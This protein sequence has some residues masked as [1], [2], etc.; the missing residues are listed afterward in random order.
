MELFLDCLPCLH[1]QVLE[2]ARIATTDE[3]C[4]ARILDRAA[5]TLTR[6]ADFA[7]APAMA[8]AMHDIVREETGVA[9]AYREIKWR[10]LDAALALE[11]MLWAF[12]AEG[13][14]RLGSAL[15]VA[16]TGNVMDSA[17]VPDLDINA[18]VSAELRRPFAR[19][20]A[21][22]LADDLATARTVL[23]VADNAG[24]AV[25]DKPLLDLLGR[26]RDV[27]YAVRDTPILNDSTL[28]E[29]RYAGVDAHARLISSG[30]STPGT[31]LD[32]CTPEF[33]ELFGAAD[34]VISKG[35]G[36]Y[37]ALCPTPRPLYLL[38]KAK[39]ALIA[40]RLGCQ[41]GDYVLE[42]REP[43]EASAPASAGTAG[44]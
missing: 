35:Q 7:S 11:P 37:E 12:A 8:K 43:N 32:T 41:V 22:A 42:R 34:V 15:K 16:A 31:I 3:A 28:E 23:V 17:L 19:C 38:L 10:E 44:R 21:A 36:N 40:R 9:D 30:C 24:E 1:R 27:V 5:V 33:L 20:D 29:A 2:A 39:C 4:Q 6:R 26:G 13:A 14:D 18:C 25:F